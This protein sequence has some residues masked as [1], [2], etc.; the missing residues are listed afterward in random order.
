MMIRNFLSNCR[1]L[2]LLTGVIIIC[3][4]SN[5]AVNDAVVHSNYYQNFSLMISEGLSEFFCHY[6]FLC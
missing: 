1:F 6:G 4:M 2:Y 3:L 5:F